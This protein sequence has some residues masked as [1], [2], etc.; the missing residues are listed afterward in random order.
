MADVCW[1]QRIDPLQN[2]R[3]KSL[4]RDERAKRIKEPSE[5]SFRVKSNP[6]MEDAMKRIRFA[7]VAA[8]ILGVTCL[9]F[10]SKPAAQN[11]APA[12]KD[13]VTYSSN[14]PDRTLAK[15]PAAAA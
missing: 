4:L 15:N 8:A 3:H 13:T 6:A 2:V 9:I 10:V 5:L 14:A 7:V 12:G 1:L 11:Q